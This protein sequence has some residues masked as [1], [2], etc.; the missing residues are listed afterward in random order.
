M[1]LERKIQ[2]LRAKRRMDLD[3][4]H[5]A[6]D[7]GENEIAKEYHKEAMVIQNVI[8][9]LTDEAHAEALERMFLTEE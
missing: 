1:T 9:L 4:Y 7:N 5:E 2:I 6:R 8:W 3:L